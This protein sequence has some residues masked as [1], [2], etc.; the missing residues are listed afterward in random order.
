MA[1]D[2]DNSRESEP[3]MPASALARKAPRTARATSAPP[4]TVTAPGRRRKVAEHV[5]SN[6]VT[7]TFA[8]CRSLGHSWVHVGRAEATDAAPSSA[9]GSI[10][11]VSTCSHCGTRRVRWFARSGMVAAHP[12]Y[13][14]PAGYETRGDDVLTLPE[15]RSAWL[16]GLLGDT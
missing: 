7:E 10:G 16:S 15:W 9:Y 1:R 5:R 6:P 4:L 14:Y 13:T 3:S 12:S 8:A 2:R 11:Y